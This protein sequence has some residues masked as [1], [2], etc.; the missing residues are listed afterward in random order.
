MEQV[1][2][3]LIT[4]TLFAAKTLP[5]IA[6][7]LVLSITTNNTVSLMLNEPADSSETTTSGRSK[8]A[9]CIPHFDALWFCYCKETHVIPV[10]CK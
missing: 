9:S 6:L 4:N 10:S 2:Q 3:V 8:E 7:W 1:S 5:V